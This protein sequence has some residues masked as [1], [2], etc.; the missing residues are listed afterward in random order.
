M[1]AFFFLLI[2]DLVIIII[3]YCCS[4]GAAFYD[5]ERYGS[6]GLVSDFNT[7]ECSW[8]AQESSLSDCNLKVITWQCIAQEC[9]AEYG[10]QCFG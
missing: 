10:M 8:N 6:A 7:F 4:V 5:D 3:I 2:N 1:V 9:S